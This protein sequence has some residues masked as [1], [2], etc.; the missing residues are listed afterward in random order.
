MQK[1][2]FVYENVSNGEPLLI[3]GND[4]FFRPIA[5]LDV[6]GKNIDFEFVQP[7]NIQPDDFFVYDLKI[8]H[9]ESGKTVCES[10]EILNNY[11]LNRKIHDYICNH[12]G[13]LLLSNLMECFYEPVYMESIY[14]IIKKLDIPFNKVIYLQGATNI[15]LHYEDSIKKLNINDK[16]NVIGYDYIE[17]SV[18]N[19]LKGKM[20]VETNFQK[21]D[22]TFLCFNRIARP[23]RID[24]YFLLKKFDLI[25]DTY[26]S[27]HNY[28]KS[29]LM[30][31]YN[32]ANFI[33]SF[34]NLKPNDILNLTQQIPMTLDKIEKYDDNINIE[35]CGDFYNKTLISLV[36]ETLISG[37]TFLTEKTFKPIYNKHPFIIISSPYFLKYLKQKGYKTFDSF[38]SEDYDIITDRNMRL[39]RIAKLC[40]DINS[41]STAKK[42]EFYE[43]SK[44]ITNHNYEVL[45][46][47]KNNDDSDF[48][49]EFKNIIFR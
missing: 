27:F 11:Q 1:I 32:D 46:N 30:S 37:P 33:R 23:H 26:Y 20:N 28:H 5:I 42:Q 15:Q 12:N 13:Y 34:L 8:Y 24:F 22:K 16:I 41:W 36:T 9:P 48:F 38:F 47:R 10:F 14:K 21:V 31:Y 2:K 19:N 25:K 7:D 49:K 45:V 17:S 29:D 6:F 35:L 43:K 4:N 3:Y 40:N 18:S 44:E 39:L